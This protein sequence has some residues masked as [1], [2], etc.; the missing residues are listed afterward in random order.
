ML[1][2]QKPHNFSPAFEAVSCII[3]Y[4]GKILLLKR[5]LRVEF[6]GSYGAPT[7]KVHKD[8]PLQT[9]MHRE[10]FE[11]TGLAVPTDS[12][13]FLKTFYVRYPQYDFIYHMYSLAIEAKPEII[14][15]PRE[16][17]EFIWINTKDALKLNLVPDMKPCLEYYLENIGEPH[18][19]AAQLGINPPEKLE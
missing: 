10:I 16:H 19:R 2:T 12:L 9:A 8:E 7:G 3:N 15:N 13:N 1:Y 17:N 5:S 6:F 11:E 18:G 14:L 4:H